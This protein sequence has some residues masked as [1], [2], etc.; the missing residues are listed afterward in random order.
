MRNLIMYHADTRTFL[1]YY[2]SRRINKIF[3]AIIRGLNPEDGIMR[4]AS[5]IQFQNIPGHGDLS[6]M[7]QVPT[8]LGEK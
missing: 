8:A 5:I 2:L 6:D 7:E 4:A 1:R 3:P